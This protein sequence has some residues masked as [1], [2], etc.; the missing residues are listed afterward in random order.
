MPRNWEQTFCPSAL[1]CQPSGE[2]AEEGPIEGA[3][4]CA[5]HGDGDL[6][7][8]V[9]VASAAGDEIVGISGHLLS[10]EWQQ[11][12]GRALGRPGNPRRMMG[13][14]KQNGTAQTGMRR[15]PEGNDVE[16]IPAKGIVAHHRAFVVRHRQE[17]CP[18]V[19]GQQ[20]PTC[21]PC[22]PPGRMLWTAGCRDGCQAPSAMAPMPIKQVPATTAGP[23]RHAE[24]RPTSPVD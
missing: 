4:P 6:L 17:P 5:C 21:H 23:P 2:I 19:F 12:G 20:P 24:W 10:D 14:T 13:I 22:P 11:R 1:G 18:L 3:M 7:A 8:P 15:P 9:L 16:I